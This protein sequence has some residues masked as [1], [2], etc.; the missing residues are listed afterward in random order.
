VSDEL[1][2]DLTYPWAQFK[3]IGAIDATLHDRIIVCSGPS[4][5]FN[6]PGLKA[7][8]AVVPNPAL[9]AQL[10]QGLQNLDL[11][12]SVDTLSTLAL[13]SAYRE[14]EDWLSQL[15]AYLEGNLAYVQHFI[16]AYLPQIQVVQP[17]AM[18]L[19]WLDCKGLGLTAEALRRLFVDEARVYAEIGNTYGLE[20]TGFVRLNIGCS[21]QLLTIALERVKVAVESLM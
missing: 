18:Y 10:M 4:K 13:Q 20:G 17:E 6:V 5:A 7:A 1:H 9:R 14:G 16:E 21:R 11:L 8:Y 3:S 19:I 15:M 2:S 12:F